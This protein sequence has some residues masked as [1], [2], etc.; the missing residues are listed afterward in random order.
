M[1]QTPGFDSEFRISEK[2][3]LTVISISD[4]SEVIKQAEGENMENYIWEL[5]QY[6]CEYFADKWQEDY[7]TVCTLRQYRKFL[8]GRGRVYNEIIATQERKGGRCGL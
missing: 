7:E 1:I 3:S 8:S 4:I 5:F 6:W 2:N